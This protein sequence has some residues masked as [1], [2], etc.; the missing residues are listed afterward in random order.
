M[1]DLD[2]TLA[3]MVQ[4]KNELQKRNERASEY[5]ESVR[6]GKSRIVLD[7]SD[8]PLCVILAAMLLLSATILF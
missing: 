4:E 7:F 5:S 2:L 3:K 1:R 8:V 6:A